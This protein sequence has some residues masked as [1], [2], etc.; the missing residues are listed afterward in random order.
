MVHH[1]F[2]PTLY[3]EFKFFHFS[4]IVMELCSGGDLY[5][6][7]HKQPDKRFSLAT[8]RF[9]AAEVLVGLEYLHMLGVIHRDLKL[10]NMLVRSNGHMMLF[11]FDLSLCSTVVSLSTNLDPSF[12]LP[13]PSRYDPRPQTIP[14]SP[15][16][17]SYLPSLNQP[18]WSCKNQNLSPSNRLFMAELIDAR[19]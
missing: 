8:A 17:F 9:Y 15:S 2:L 13:I 18:F 11:D 3:T 19:S 6:L 1:P 10:E 4:C 16:L 14:P 7:L 12:A 5:S